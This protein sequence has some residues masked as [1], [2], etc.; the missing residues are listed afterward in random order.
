MKKY[1]AYFLGILSTLALILTLLVTSID[2]VAFHLPGYYEKEYTKYQVAET[3]NMEMNDLLNVTD[4]MLLYLR[5]ERG[6]LHVPTVVGGEEREFFNE[7]E[8]AHMVDVRDLILWA[9]DMRTLAFGILLVGL[10]ILMV[11]KVDLKTVVTRSFLWGAGIFTVVLLGLGI[12]ISTDFTRYFTI[13][14]HIFFRN[15]LWLLDP[16]TDLLI[17]IVPEPFFM[18]TALRI[19]VLFGGA[20]L[21]LFILCAGAV[22]KQKKAL[23]GETV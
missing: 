3:V 14:H 7:R 23:R 22:K 19:G 16:N 1:M 21:L 5:G 6:D 20:L 12:L 8:M 4:E 13:F 18:D 9:F 17:N 15:D 11:M 10:A 2:V